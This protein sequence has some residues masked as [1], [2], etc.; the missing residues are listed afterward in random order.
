[1]ALLKSEHEPVRSN[2][3]HINAI[4]TLWGH[5]V[6]GYSDFYVFRDKTTLERWLVSAWATFSKSL[7]LSMDEKTNRNFYAVLCRP[8]T[9]SHQRCWQ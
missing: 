4:D 8:P 6:L 3:N 7:M 1:M 2:V 9:S 5:V